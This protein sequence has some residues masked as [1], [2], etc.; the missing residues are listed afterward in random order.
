MIDQTQASESELLS[1]IRKIMHDVN[2]PL[3]VINLSLSRLETVMETNP[4]PELSV[5][6]EEI[7]ASADK[8][9]EIFSTLDQ[10]RAM[11]EVSGI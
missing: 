9:L 3:C 6:Y 4:H 5:S 1:L 7:S 8:L 11:I 10:A 2:T